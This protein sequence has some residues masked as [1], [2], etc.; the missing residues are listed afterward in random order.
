MCQEEMTG[1]PLL[2]PAGVPDDIAAAA[3]ELV[4]G[5]AIRI[6]WTDGHTTGIYTYEWLR[7]HCPC[8]RCTGE[9]GEGTGVAA[10]A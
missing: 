2:D 7:A 1:R 9:R 8:P 4:G 5:Y 10:R 3:I 6:N